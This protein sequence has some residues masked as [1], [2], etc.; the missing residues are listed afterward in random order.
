[1]DMRASNHVLTIHDNAASLAGKLAAAVAARL[2]AAIAERGRASLAVSGGRTPAAFFDALSRQ[3]IAWDRVD[4]TLV[5]ERFVAETSERS[6]ARLVRERLL[7]NQAAAARFH[8]LW[9]DDRTVEA[10]AF[11]ADGELYPLVRRLDVVVLGMGEDGH[12]ASYFPDA[13]AYEKLFLACDAVMAV[14]APSAGEERLTIS[15]RL[16]ANAGAIFLHFEGQAKKD[17][18]DAALA[19]TAPTPLPVATVVAMAKTPVSLH[20]TI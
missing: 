4:V 3:E 20:W 8:P 17:L 11:H 19:S 7:V 5:D 13:A 1:M 6:N 10:A 9:R 12:V 15:P 16:I 18:F 2:E 14:R